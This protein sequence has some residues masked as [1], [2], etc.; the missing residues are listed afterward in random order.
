MGSY[1]S[2]TTDEQQAAEAPPKYNPPVYGIVDVHTQKVTFADPPA[3]EAKPPAP[4]AGAADTPEPVLKW[5]VARRRGPR[6]QL[7][8]SATPKATADKPKRPEPK[9]STASPAVAAAIAAAECPA[10]APAVAAATP[11]PRA[12]TAAKK[13]KKEAPTAAAVAASVPEL[14]VVGKAA[15]VMM[16]REKRGAV[17]A[18][19]IGMKR[20]AKRALKPVGQK[21][22]RAKKV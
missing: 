22:G 8:A 20:V 3:S 10:P 17:P 19:K 14:V 2:K 13:A 21:G 16:K 6:A 1:L 9:A 11:K 15:K 4:A 12:R 7:P 5:E 18:Q